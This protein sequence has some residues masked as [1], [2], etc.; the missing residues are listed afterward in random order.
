LCRLRNTTSP[1]YTYHMAT[2]RDNISPAT[3]ATEP[4]QQHL[5][6]H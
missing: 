1:E 5:D 3:T 4:Q 6:L 2:A